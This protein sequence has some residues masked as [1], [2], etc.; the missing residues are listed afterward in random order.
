MPWPFGSSFPNMGIWIKGSGAVGHVS[1]MAYFWHFLEDKDERL[2]TNFTLILILRFNLRHGRYSIWSASLIAPHIKEDLKTTRG[3]S[4][5][6]PRSSQGS[7]RKTPWRRCSEELEDAFRST[8]MLAVLDYNEL[9]G[10]SDLG[11]RDCT[12][13]VHILG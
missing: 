2:K 6:Q 3:T 5:S 9:G 1:S 12:H 7:T 11:P 13:G 4:I 8:W 10:F